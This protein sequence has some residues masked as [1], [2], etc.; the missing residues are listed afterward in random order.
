MGVPTVVDATNLVR[1]LV[2]DGADLQP[3]G[4]QMIVT[5]REIDLLIDR[6]AT[7]IS[8]VINFALNP[9]ISRDLIKSIIA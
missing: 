3:D 8:E 1:D 2:G 9:N 4:R 7:L 5:P 6:A